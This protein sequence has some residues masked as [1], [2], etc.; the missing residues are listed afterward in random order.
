VILNAAPPPAILSYYVSYFIERVAITF[1]VLV[2]FASPMKL[3]PSTAWKLQI[4]YHGAPSTGLDW[5][6]SARPMLQQ[7]SSSPK[8][9]RPSAPSTSS[10]ASSRAAIELR[11][12][13]PG[14]TDNALAR[15]CAHTIASWKPLP[16][17]PVRRMPEVPRLRRVR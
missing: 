3:A 7:C 11:R 17:R 14:I 16:L 12:R 10:G 15:E 4:R 8:R 5:P 13:F 9:M 6:T 1:R 2:Q